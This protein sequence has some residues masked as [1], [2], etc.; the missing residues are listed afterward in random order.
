M[1]RR[2]KAKEDDHREGKIMIGGDKC[3]ILD[4]ITQS[5]ENM[6]KIKK[7]RHIMRYA[8]DQTWHR[9]VQ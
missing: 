4:K 9:G 8:T 2:I 6:H 3:H 1:W 7:M 5:A